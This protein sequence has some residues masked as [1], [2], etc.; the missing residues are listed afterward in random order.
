[1]LYAYSEGFVLV[2]S[3]TMRVVHG[4]GSMIGKMPGET[5]EKKAEEPE[6]YLCLYDGA[7]RQEA[8][9]HGPGIRLDG[10]EWNEGA[11]PGVGLLEVSCSQEHAG[12][13]EGA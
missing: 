12:L 2:F 9:V 1:M 8:A 10:C 7:S 11:S 6:G 13:C 4:K 3:P 5:L